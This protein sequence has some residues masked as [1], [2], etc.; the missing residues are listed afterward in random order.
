M[1]RMYFNMKNEELNTEE[2]RL[3]EEIAAANLLIMTNTTKLNRIEREKKEA[4]TPEFKYMI[5]LGKLEPVN[6][7]LKFTLE[8]GLPVC[9]DDYGMGSVRWSLVKTKEEAK[10]RQLIDN[11]IWAVNRLS[12][13]GNEYPE[14]VPELK[15]IILTGGKSRSGWENL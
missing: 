2:L 3:A 5:V 4:I 1:K 8:N 10:E 15:E 12:Y 7:N 14:E 6:R 9:N 11:V 13:A